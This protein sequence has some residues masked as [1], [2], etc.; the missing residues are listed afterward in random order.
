MNIIQQLKNN[1]VGNYILPFLWLKGEDRSIICQEIEQ[2]YNCGI[3]A[4][5]IESRP[6]PDFMGERWWSD[7]A[8]IIQEAKKRDMK[9]WI[10]DDAHFPTGYANGLIQT[11]YPE[12]RKKYLNYNVVDVWGETGEVTIPVSRMLKPLVSFMD[13]DKPR[14]VEELKNNKLVT[15]VAYPMKEDNKLDEENGIVL[16]DKVEGEY[17]HFTFPR[18]NYRVYVVYETYAG[19]GKPNYINMMDKKSVSTLIEAIYEPHYEH[20]KDEFGETIAGFFSDEPEIGNVDGFSSDVQIGNSR[21][22]LPWSDQLK[23]IM[24][25]KYN[26][27]W[28][29]KI[30]F[31]WAET[32][33]MI[34]CPKVRYHFMDAVSTLYSENFSNQLGEWCTAHHVEYIG[35]VVEDDNLHGRLGNG[36]AHFFRAM[37]GQHMAG[38]DV[39]ANQVT[40][41]GANYVRSGI[42][43]RDGEFMHYALGKLG[44]SSGHLDPKKQG[45]TMC[46]LFG[47]SGWKTGV[48]DM[49]YIVDHLLVRGVNVFVP[50]AFSMAEYPDPD[51]PPHFYG[52]GN[53]PQFRHFGNL[54]QYLNRMGEIF[55]NGKHIASVAVLYHADA[56]WS[57]ECMLIQKP[58][59]ELLQNQ[60]EFDFVSVDM[61]QDLR[62]EHDNKGKSV[63]SINDQKFQCLVIPYIQ[64]LPYGVYRFLLEN[65]N[66]KV[67]FVGGYPSQVLQLEKNSNDLQT[68]W[69]QY[70]VLPLEKLGDTLKTYG[71]G[72]I[73]LSENFPELTYYHYDNGM[74]VFMFNNE[75]AF[76][77]FQGD[78]SLPLTRGALYYD[79]IKNEFYRMEINE[80]HG[81]RSVHL[82]LRPYGSCVIFDTEEGDFP[83]Y[84]TCSERLNQA[85][86]ELDLSTGWNYSTAKE[87]EYPNFGASKNMDILQPFSR[88]VPKFSGHICYEK[89]FV[90]EDSSRYIL[91]EF[92]NVFEVMELWINHH[93]V[94]VIQN[95]PYVFDVS[96]FIR[97]GTNHIKAIVTTTADRD[98]LHYP[99]PFV[100]LSH[101]V[102]E[103]TGMYGNVVLRYE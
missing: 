8:M 57:G 83:K 80:T 18:E 78:I 69:K 79:G 13:L 49:K 56:E 60:I 85:K 77:T 30:P 11:K 82:E 24:I 102:I 28:V 5:C 70:E 39:I 22:P 35:H 64:N 99:E 2:I 32:I 16:T 62:E 55:Q 63:F 17:I 40:I 68:F 50:H 54:M 65:P 47:A 36:A 34:E 96:E 6:H 74:N 84:R 9:V 76:E 19:G 71:M 23:E 33:Q 4:L 51:C 94:G 103:P 89:Q 81:K 3:R 98:Q 1:Q 58:A 66:I 73:Q 101:D 42:F 90:M 31:L 15:V 91:L 38:I 87:S 26:E 41:G 88:I 43:E 46:E 14:D 93:K 52:R 25:S 72:T 29:T 86:R 100:L 44:A 10:L 67:L 48:R 61:L 75:S 12:R 59:K 21:M 20:F 45:R 95:P 92:T 97:E 7:L 27:L 37:K 53:N